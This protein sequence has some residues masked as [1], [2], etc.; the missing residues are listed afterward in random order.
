MFAITRLNLDDIE[1][2]A[3]TP[4]WRFTIGSP[5]HERFVRMVREHDTIEPL[6][7][8]ALPNGRFVLVGGFNRYE[9]EQSLGKRTVPCAVTALYP[10]YESAVAHMLGRMDP[11]FWPDDLLLSSSRFLWRLPCWHSN[12]GAFVGRWKYD[13]FR[14]VVTEIEARE[15]EHRR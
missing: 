15:K 14:R 6:V 3:Y 12:I 10:A 11:T 5:E 9:I 4:E 2:Y 1:P 13:R 8:N 7:V